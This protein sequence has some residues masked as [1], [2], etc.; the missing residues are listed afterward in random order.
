MQFQEGKQI[1][2]RWLQNQ[3]H[4]NVMSLVILGREALN[5]TKLGQ[6]WSEE[7]GGKETQ[8]E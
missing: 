1:G 4:W 3:P 7:N 6:I 2:P 8:A 5:K